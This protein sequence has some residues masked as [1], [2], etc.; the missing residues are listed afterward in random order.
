MNIHFYTEHGHPSSL[1]VDSD[2]M[3]FALSFLS[4]VLRV[5]QCACETARN[6]SPIRR[7][8][9]ASFPDAPFADLP[10]LVRMRLAQNALVEYDENVTAP[11][12]ELA[13]N[14]VMSSCG[15]ALRLQARLMAQCHQYCFI[16]GGDRAWVAD[17]I[18]E[19]V[20]DAVL[21]PNNGWG[22]LMRLLRRNNDSPVV[23]SN[24][25]PF[26]NSTIAG[27]Q[28]DVE[29]WASLDYSQQW[30]RSMANLR[31]LN[32]EYGKCLDIQPRQWGSVLFGSGATGFHVRAYMDLVDV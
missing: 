30:S 4:M 11:A 18:E 8:I 20:R 9:H 32:D 15:G 6:P 5:D 13:L 25:A 2:H 19:G 3:S 22:R 29:A 31:R 23:A 16:E 1:V 12:H 26:P 21:R 7:V 27:L 14:T 10:A 24:H 17:I 28:D